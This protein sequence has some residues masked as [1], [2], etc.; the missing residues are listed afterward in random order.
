MARREQVGEQRF[1]EIERERGPIFAVNGV[2]LREEVQVNDYRARIYSD[3]MPLP[4]AKHVPR[5][6]R[7]LAAAVNG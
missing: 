3:S 6:T 7:A 2:K 4:P 1:A 5:V